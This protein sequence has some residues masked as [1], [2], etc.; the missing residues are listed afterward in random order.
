MVRSSTLQDAVERI[1]LTRRRL[2]LT[3]GIVT[4]VLGIAVYFLLPDCR[5]LDRTS[6]LQIHAD[7]R[8]S[9]LNGKVALARGK[10]IH[11]KPASHQFS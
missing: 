10:S 5:Y 11:S 9:P 7:C 6:S 3:E 8:I 2:I 1:L 4:I